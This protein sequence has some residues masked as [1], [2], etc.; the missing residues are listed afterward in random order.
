MARQAVKQSLT[1]ARPAWYNQAMDDFCYKLSVR[2]FTEDKCFGPGLA[3]LLALVRERRSLRAA[4]AEMGMA[5]SKAWRILRDCETAL[6]FPLL[7][8]TT[9]GKNGGGAVL[10]PK[11]ERLLADYEDFCRGLTAQADVLFQSHLGHW[12]Q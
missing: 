2:L 8:S 7:D 10:T 5:Y 3:T 9:G 12:T 4:A 11:G 6:G 1:A